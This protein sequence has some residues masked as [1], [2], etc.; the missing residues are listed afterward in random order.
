MCMCMCL[1]ASACVC[2]RAKLSRNPHPPTASGLS[3]L[4]RAQCT[5]NSFADKASTDKLFSKSFARRSQSHVA[6]ERPRSTG[7]SARPAACDPLAFAETSQA[8]LPCYPEPAMDCDWD[9]IPDAEPTPL[10]SQQSARPSAG[11]HRN[12]GV[13][14]E[15]RPRGLTKKI[16][17]EDLERFLA[18]RKRDVRLL[19]RGMDNDASGLTGHDRDIAFQTSWIAT[20]PDRPGYIGCRPCAK[21]QKACPS[22]AR[23]FARYQVRTLKLSTILKHGSSAFHRSN[24]RLF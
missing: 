17:Q 7:T 19:P 20:R 23:A 21:M 24:T 9:T 3:I 15:D 22:G 16:G 11:K 5:R 12:G 2:V 1:R 13:D 8:H 18:K 14:H 10:C 6:N 4:M